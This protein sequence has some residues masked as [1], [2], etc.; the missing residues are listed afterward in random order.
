MDVW[1]ETSSEVSVITCCATF[2][3]ILCLREQVRALWHHGFDNYMR[4]GASFPHAVSRGFL[5]TWHQ[6][7]L[8]MR[9]TFY[10]DIGM[11]S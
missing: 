10:D 6:L 2:C 3:W 8:L 4:F 5:N 9:C 1:E 11:L 7:S